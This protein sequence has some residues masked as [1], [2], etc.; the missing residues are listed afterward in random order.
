M[1]AKR[2]PTNG[3][4]KGASPNPNGRPKGPG[5]KVSS[6]RG[7]FNKL[8]KMDQEAIDA[9]QASLT[10]GSTIDKDKVQTAKWVI[11][12][13]ATLHKACL[14]EEE[15]KS[16]NAS[17]QSNSDTPV[18]DGADTVEDEVDRSKIEN[19]FSIE[20]ATKTLTKKE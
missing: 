3:F 4:K 5:K 9:I 16:A 8:K 18:G 1:T 2:Q 15:E 14:S 20:M 13:I 6:L 19:V 10:E 12:T 11:T 17:A 7:I